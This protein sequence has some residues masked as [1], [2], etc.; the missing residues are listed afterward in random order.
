MR[1]L[2]SLSAWLVIVALIASQLAPG[3]AEQDRS[4]VRTRKEDDSPPVRLG[5]I[6]TC[7]SLSAPHWMRR[8]RP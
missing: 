8:K 6:P 7:P 3:A 2:I 5:K 4:E 1:S